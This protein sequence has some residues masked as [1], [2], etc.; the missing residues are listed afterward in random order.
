MT[1]GF[2]EQVR[3]MW[4]GPGHLRFLVQPLVAITLGILDGRKD[5]RRALPPFGVAVARGPAAERRARLGSALRRITVPLVLA[6]VL[7]ILFQAII[8]AQWRPLGTLL[9]A[10]FFV[11]LPY[12][13]A[14][15]IANRALRPRRPRPRRAAETPSEA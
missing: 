8:L 14:R 3:A 12:G 9:F 5:A 4:E 6:T 10:V 11:V 15:G 2:F 7:S 1:D 13:A